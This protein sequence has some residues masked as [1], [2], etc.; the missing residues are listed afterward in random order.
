MN[1]GS[2]WHPPAGTAA[3]YTSVWEPSEVATLD[4]VRA[5]YALDSAG[6]TRVAVAFLSYVLAL[7]GH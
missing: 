5:H 4:S 2:G 6:A 7:G 1:H 3:S